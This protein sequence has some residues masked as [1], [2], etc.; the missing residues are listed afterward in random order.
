MAVPTTSIG[1]PESGMPPTHETDHL[2]LT[3]PVGGSS[4]SG[5]VVKVELV[6]PVEVIEILDSDEEK[7]DER[8]KA[9]RWWC[10]TS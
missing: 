2:G 1:I 8:P 7:G 4:R 10:S 3:F 5:E 9:T 6:T